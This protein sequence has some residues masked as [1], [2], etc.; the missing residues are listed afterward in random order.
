MDKKMKKVQSITDQN[1]IEV[2][3]RNLTENIIS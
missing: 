2:F 1:Q 3:S